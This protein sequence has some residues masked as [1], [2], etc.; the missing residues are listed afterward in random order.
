M[1]GSGIGL[2]LADVEASRGSQRLEVDCCQVFSKRHWM[3]LGRD[4]CG[5]LL[6][7]PRDNY[8]PASRASCDER[9]PDVAH[10]EHVGQAAGWTCPWF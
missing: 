5:S 2:Q 6:H 7:E 4:I 3:S 1:A 8:Q 9:S 10:L